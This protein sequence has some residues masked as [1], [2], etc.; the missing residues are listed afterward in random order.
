MRLAVA[1]VVHVVV[2]V[3]VGPAGAVLERVF[4]VGAGAA[5]HGADVVG[6]FVGSGCRCRVVVI[7]EGSL[8]TYTVEKMLGRL[9]EDTVRDS[10]KFVLS[11]LRQMSGH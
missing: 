10:Q 9:K 1:R 3:V 11:K 7:F 4:V 8:A 5:L 2:H 6:H